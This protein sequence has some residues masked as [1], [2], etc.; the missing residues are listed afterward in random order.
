[1]KLIAITPDFLD[2][3]G[4]L[5]SIIK[6]KEYGVSHLYLRSPFI[7]SSPNFKAVLKKLK[8]AGFELI[9]PYDKWPGV[10]SIGVIPH[11]KERDIVCIDNLY[12]LLGRNP[13]SASV[14]TVEDAWEVIG[15][16]AEFIF[17]SPIFSPYSKKDYPLQ[18]LD[19]E[20]VAKVVRLYGERIVLLGGIDFDRVK[21]L[22]S[23]LK[24]DFS[25]AGITMFFGERG[26]G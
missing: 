20:E 14:H 16:G 25:I 7:L 17:L 18:P 24:C 26:K 5:N 13:F 2:V 1:M 11:F 10:I 3:K 6:L 23:R 21:E 8:K 9:V 22:K 12:W 15:K 4:L 19:L